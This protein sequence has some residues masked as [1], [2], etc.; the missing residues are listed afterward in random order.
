VTNPDGNIDA[1]QARQQGR[2]SEL[3]PQP[4]QEFVRTAAFLIARADIDA[5]LAEVVRLRAAFHAEQV[6]GREA[7]DQIAELSTALEQTVSA[8][9][10][11][12]HS[13]YTDWR[14]CDDS[15]CRRAAGLL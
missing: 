2:H 9:H 1:I 3:G 13:V 7:R 11:E 4:G 15:R 6:A 8:L 5:L 10:H 12:A 14:I